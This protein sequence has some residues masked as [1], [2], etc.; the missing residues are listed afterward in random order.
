MTDN[1]FYKT[2]SPISFLDRSAEVY[3]DKPALSYGDITYTYQDFYDRVNKL[4]GALLKEGV[5]K[6]DRV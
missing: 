2:L 6:G 3:P 5:K 1:M 4:A